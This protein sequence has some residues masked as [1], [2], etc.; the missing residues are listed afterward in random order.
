MDHETLCVN[1]CIYMYMTLHMTMIACTNTGPHVLY[2]AMYQH[3]CSILYV[4]VLNCCSYI[5]FSAQNLPQTGYL[6]LF[7]DQ[8]L[9][10]MSFE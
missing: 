8:E 10:I 9:K 3:N 7:Y 1:A 5:T 2:T 4:S 6:C